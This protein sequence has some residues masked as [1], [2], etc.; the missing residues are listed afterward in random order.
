MKLTPKHHNGAT[1]EFRAS[2]KKGRKARN[3]AKKSKQKNR[4]KGRK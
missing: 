4:R 1:D 2:V 3:M